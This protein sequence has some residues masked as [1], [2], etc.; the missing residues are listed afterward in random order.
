MKINKC[1]FCRGKLD[2]VLSLGDF[3]VVNYFPNESEIKKEKKY[4][5]EL[6]ICRN[7]GLAQLNFILDPKKIFQKYHYLSS[8]SKPLVK[9]LHNLAS[10]AIKKFNLTNSSK[11]LDIGSNDGVLLE[12]FKKKHI[13]AVGVEPSFNCSEISTKKGF[14]VYENFF[15]QKLAKKI[16]QDYGGFDLIAIT[17]TLANIVDLNDFMRGV[18]LLLKKN[19]VLVIEVGSLKKMLSDFKFDS[20]YHEH[21]S[22][23]SFET[24]SK[25]LA[26]HNLTIIYSKNNLFH[27]GSLRV[28]AVHKE[29][30]TKAS[31]SLGE[32]VP[33]DY[34]KFVSQ[35]KIRKTKLQNL[36]SS[37]EGSLIVGY[38]APAKSVTLLNYLSLRSDQISFIVD[39]TPYKQGR[40]LPGAHIPVFP[41]EHLNKVKV[42]YIFLLA[43]NYKDEI[44]KK[45]KSLVKKPVKV[46]LPFSREIIE[47]K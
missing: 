7:C 33:S 25:L 10:D 23:F 16:Y 19:G 17:H 5:L 30:N 47:I 43:W 40:F 24:L 6:C 41:E 21:Y 9:H 39:S 2:L 26:K 27:G 28:F 14:R 8:V 36:F 13:E 34:K 18:K 1:R 31:K 3:P 29:I 15:D 32:V 44:L 46:I 38:G 45:I 22:Y 35:I 37:L 11:I 12:E 4:P 42:D 20:I